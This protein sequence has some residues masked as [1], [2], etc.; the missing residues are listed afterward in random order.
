MTAKN[1]VTGV[2]VVQA[3]G[4]MFN[5][6]STSKDGTVTDMAS[7]N[8]AMSQMN[9]GFNEYAPT[10]RADAYRMSFR[11]IQTNTSV[12]TGF[13]RGDYNYFRPDEAVPQRFKD[14]LFLCQSV[15][16]NVP[17][18]KQIVDLMGDFSTKGIRLVH[19]NPEIQKYYEKWFDT[20][21]GTHIT[22]RFANSFLRLGVSYIRR[23]TVKLTERQERKVYR[24]QADADL[25]YDFVEPEPIGRAEIPLK[26]TLYDP[27]TVENLGGS[28][29]KFVGESVYALELPHDIRQKVQHPK[30]PEEVDLIKKL[31]PD[32]K[33]AIS[34]GNKL[35]IPPD[36]LR[37][38]HYKKDDWSEWAHPMIYPILKDII[39]LEKLKLADQTALDGVISK[40]RVWKLGSLE[41]KI[42][43][44]PDAINKFSEFLLNNVGGGTIDIVWGPA[45]DLLETDVGTEGILGEDKYKP[46][47]SSI[48][49]GLGV[50][51]TLTGMDTK[52]GFTNNSV[53]LKTLIERLQYIRD[54]ITE[55]WAGEI[56]IVRKAKGFKLPAEV[57]FDKI[58]LT[59]EASQMAL[60]KDMVDRD[61]I[62][63]EYVREAIGVIPELEERRVRREFKAR[64]TGKNPP[65]SDAF[66]QGGNL[67]GELKKI[68]LTS[69]QA[70]PTQVGL[71]L[72]EKKE[73]EVS[74]MEHNK[75]I[76]ETK[77]KQQA[78]RP[79]NKKDG[80]KRKTKT[81]KPVRG[82]A[83]IIMWAAKA[84][85]EIAEVI[86]PAL[87]ATYKK[88]NLRQLT[89]AEFEDSEKVKFAL[90]AAFNPF[91]E[92]TQDKVVEKL[93][94]ALD[95]SLLQIYQDYIDAF[96]VQFGKNPDTD[97]LRN[98]QQ[99]SYA[100]WAVSE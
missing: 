27:L 41:H 26:Y 44:G 90:L 71:E 20:I 52:G 57:M 14:I 80:K 48:Y 88:K 68:A 85:K 37:V 60:L 98:L 36:K 74:L 38:F 94:I 30:T 39:I 92:V 17:I 66:R 76:A 12:R 99:I 35:I 83:N 84:Q 89:T 7:F 29:S 4:P 49:A 100:K 34:K 10:Q 40:V 65:R 28:L 91:E 22:E 15:Y 32:I 69:G 6:W 73:G 56:E 96:I 1:K 9:K 95:S 63:Y 78:G 5:C 70:T 54:V 59:D 81:V 19:Q 3:A 53:S 45:I 23:Y 46:I 43:P 33:E 13:N 25:D 93:G 2:P 16:Q 42:V 77:I 64:E 11:D 72:E 82:V 55:F 86:N 67:E 61:L 47:L 18:V 31:T 75:Q 58:V 50:P 51:P 79:I 8:Y 24:T 21:K 97:E 87:L 62:S